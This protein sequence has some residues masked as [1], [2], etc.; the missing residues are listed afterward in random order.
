MRKDIQTN[1]YA[2][3][4]RK[5]RKKT[6]TNKQF[7]TVGQQNKACLRRFILMKI[8]PGPSPGMHTVLPKYA[9][10]IDGDTGDHATRLLRFLS[11]DTG[12]YMPFFQFFLKITR[13]NANAHNVH[14]LTPIK[15]C[16][17][18]LTL[19]APSRRPSWQILE[20]RLTK[21]PTCISLS[22]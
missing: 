18:T 13:S 5:E 12:V 1:I 22:T 21:S 19:R 10:C 8:R 4:S 17:Q 11:F 6:Y 16:M 7:G 20:T 14:T 2:L 3:E 9:R 15:V